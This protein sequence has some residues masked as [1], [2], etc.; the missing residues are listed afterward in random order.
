M[1]IVVCSK[2]NLKYTNIYVRTTYYYTWLHWVC[3][4]I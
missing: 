3:V 2:N 1:L 4:C